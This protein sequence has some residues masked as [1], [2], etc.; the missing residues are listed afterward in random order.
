MN[1]TFHSQSY[2][3]SLLLRDWLRLCPWCKG[4]SVLKTRPPNSEPRR[5]CGWINAWILPEPAGGP[6]G[7]TASMP[8]REGHLQCSEQQIR[9]MKRKEQE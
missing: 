2:E 7:R 1:L 3:N 6:A 4:H 9:R 5:Q 8:P